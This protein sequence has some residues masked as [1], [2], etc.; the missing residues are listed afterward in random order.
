MLITL[1]PTQTKVIALNTTL[2][3]LIAKRSS[4]LIDAQKMEA[5]LT[6][7]DRSAEATGIRTNLCYVTRLFRE[8]IAM[9]DE[10]IKTV[11]QG[12]KN[13]NLSA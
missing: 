8:H 11:Q 2:Q 5:Q 3:L 4:A 7:L 13:T 12:R 10:S 6:R 1:H 9:L